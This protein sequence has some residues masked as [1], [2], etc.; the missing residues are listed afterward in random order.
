MVFLCRHGAP[1]RLVLVLDGGGSRAGRA[2]SA[3]GHGRDGADEREPTEVWG[4]A[5]DGHKYVPGRTL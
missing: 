3:S 4:P 2:T 1:P 5:I